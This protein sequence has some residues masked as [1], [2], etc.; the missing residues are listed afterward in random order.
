MTN[1]MTSQNID[2]PSWN[3][4]YKKIFKLFTGVLYI[5]TYIQ[6]IHLHKIAFE[7]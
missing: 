7:Q 4:L 1:A 6:F 5:Y 3:I 2:L